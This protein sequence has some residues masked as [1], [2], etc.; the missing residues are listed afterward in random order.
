MRSCNGTL[1]KSDAPT[2]GLV[3]TLG[4]LQTPI[5]TNLSWLW[6]IEL[7]QSKLLDAIWFPV[8]ARTRN[9]EILTSGVPSP[10]NHE[11]PSIAVTCYPV[12]PPQQRPEKIV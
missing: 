10:L 9:V 8:K 6:P 12:P 2:M 7:F 5:S 4:L 1:Y 11:R 3:L